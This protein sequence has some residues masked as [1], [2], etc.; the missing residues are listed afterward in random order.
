MWALGKVMKMG[1][2]LW[3]EGKLSKEMHMWYVALESKIQR[4]L[5]V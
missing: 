2:N 3:Y 5:L 1:W 4:L